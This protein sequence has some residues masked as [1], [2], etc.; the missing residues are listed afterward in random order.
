MTDTYQ[1]KCTGDQIAST[2]LNNGSERRTTS[3]DCTPNGVFPVSLSFNLFV[4][5]LVHA[6]AYYCVFSVST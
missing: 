6:Y 5:C 2:P 1:T 3:S 4:R